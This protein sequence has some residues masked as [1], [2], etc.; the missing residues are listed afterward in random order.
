MSDYWHAVAMLR[1]DRPR[2]LAE[3]ETCFTEGKAAEG[4][5]GFRSGRLIATT[6]GYGLDGALE[7]LARVWLP[8][9]GKSFSRQA[10]EG[11]NLFTPGGRRAIRAAFPR[12]AGI[13]EDDEGTSAFRF[14]TSVGPSATYTD[15]SVL[16]LDYRDI[17]GNPSFPVRRVLD[18]LVQI[19]DGLFLGQALMWWS[20][21]L[22]R[23]AW[24]SL[25]A[26]G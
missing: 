18:E 3:V 14:V 17:V 23:I 11:I 20:G 4:L 21:R 26:S 24:F 12:Y 2:G 1:L 9:R 10:A 5:V 25:E 16:R 8:W 13:G 19:G 7:G 22:R 6:V 15:L